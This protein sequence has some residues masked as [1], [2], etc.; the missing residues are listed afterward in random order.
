MFFEQRLIG[1]LAN[2]GYLIG[3]PD[4][5]RAAV[6]VLVLGVADFALAKRRHIKDLM[7]TREEVKQEHKNSEGD[8]HQKAKRKAVHKQLATGGAARGCKKPLSWW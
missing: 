6:I 7:M 3:D 5:K 1:Q 4:V 2:L 8:P